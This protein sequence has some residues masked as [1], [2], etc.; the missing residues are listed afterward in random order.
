MLSNNLRGLL[1]IFLVI[2]GPAVVVAGVVGAY[3][4][5]G[6]RL[7]ELLSLSDGTLQQYDTDF[8]AVDQPFLSIANLF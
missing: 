6:L 2:L 5:V 8:R 7:W 1:V 4:F 3:P